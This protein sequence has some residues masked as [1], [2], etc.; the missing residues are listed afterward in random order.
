MP[1][2]LAAKNIACTC[3]DTFACRRQVY[4]PRLSSAHVCRKRKLLAWS[5][6]HLARKC[7]ALTC[8]DQ[9]GASHMCVMSTAGLL[10]RTQTRYNAAS[11]C[12]KSLCL[13]AL[14][15]FHHSEHCRT[16]VLLLHLSQCG[17]ILLPVQ[18]QF[19]LQDCMHFLTAV[20]LYMYRVLWPSHCCIW[21]TCASGPAELW[22]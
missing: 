17:H 21:C 14:A 7:V 9:S 5:V 8:C 3:F 11:I 2:T 10:S 4:K 15:H 18:M 6:W 20:K 16:R 19:M 22:D 12:N 1:C 13:V